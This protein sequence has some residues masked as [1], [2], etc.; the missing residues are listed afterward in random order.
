MPR[1]RPAPR[2]KGEEL[3]RAASVLRGDFRNPC[4]KRRVSFP[5]RREL[6]HGVRFRQSVASVRP[7]IRHTCTHQ[8]YGTTQLRHSTARRMPPE[9]HA[10]SPSRELPTGPVPPVTVVGRS[11]PGARLRPRGHRA[12]DA[13]R[14]P[15]EPDFGPGIRGGVR[16]RGHHRRRRCRCRRRAAP[17]PRPT[18]PRPPPP[19]RRSSRTYPPAS[20]PRYRPRP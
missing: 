4:A 16:H 18:T 19:T 11:V 1:W 2:G 20:R 6:P 9:H 13:G 15:C 7:R 5:T 3:S 10:G 12:G 14:K 17:G 8:R